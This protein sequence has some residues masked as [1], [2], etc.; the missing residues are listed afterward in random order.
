MGKYGK[1]FWYFGC[2]SIIPLF[3]FVHSAEAL[4]VNNDPDA[5][6]LSIELDNN[7]FTIEANNTPFEEVL[8]ELSH[9]TGAEF[10]VRDALLLKDL[11]SCSFMDLT[12][13]DATA[14]L[15]KNY[16]YILEYGKNNRANVI[17]FASKG[18]GELFTGDKAVSGQSLISHMNTMHVE[19]PQSLDECQKLDFTE[20][21][22][23]V[24]EGLIYQ[25]PKNARMY[26]Q[27]LEADRMAL[28]DA[29]INRARNVLAMER[30]AHFWENVIRELSKIQDDRV[31]SLLSDIA[32][33]G[34]TPAL[35]TAAT[36]TLWRN[37]AES[38]FKN[39][40]GIN[41]LKNLTTSSDEGVRHYAQQAVKDYENYMKRTTS[42]A[43]Q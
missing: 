19:N 39:L 4:D 40:K 13:S 17:I 3:I 26:R 5:Y 1:S 25:D 11:I 24:N 21:D 28:E 43:E 16:N 7:L 42:G 9:K 37:T 15:L 32:K 34:K 8:K 20:K 10:I 14:R 36:E 18:S 41:A 31:T 6:T 12:F 2:L 27:M 29:K 30:C 33:N 22:M 38:E 23:T 35:K